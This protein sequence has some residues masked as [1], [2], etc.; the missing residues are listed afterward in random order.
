I[1][2]FN[3]YLIE[4]VAGSFSL[5]SAFNFTLWYVV[6][7]RKTIKPLLRDVELRFFL[8]IASGVIIVTSFQVWHIGMYDL[9]G[10]VVHS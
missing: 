10:S 6:I 8:L 1:G 5:L 3:N 2:Y 9:T 7:S 4:L